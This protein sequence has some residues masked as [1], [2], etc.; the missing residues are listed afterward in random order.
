MCFSAQASFV[1]GIGLLG[2]GIVTVKSVR[3]RAELLYGLI[4]LLFGLQQLV[5]GLI[6][7][8]FSQQAPMLR[9][10]LSYIYLLFSNVLW[11]IYIPVA[12]LAIESDKWR[13]YAVT[14]FVCVGA[15]VSAYLV[16]ILI[17]HPVTTSV[18]CQHIL[19][20]FPNT[21]EQTTMALYVIATCGSLLV[22]SH[23]RV[24]LFGVV[25]LISEVIAYEFY[26]N[27]YISTWCFFAALLS[28]IVLWQFQDQKLVSL[29]NRVWKGP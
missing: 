21:Y 11:P 23:K 7:Q 22:S 2:L 16:A 12:V 24:V 17:L 9:V 8:T 29:I 1:A 15:A 5:E 13:R 3:N 19:Y 27:W 20:E 25:A 18:N 28:V 6:W 14:G 26:A 4:P 10:P